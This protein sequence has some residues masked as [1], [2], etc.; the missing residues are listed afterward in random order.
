MKPESSL[1]NLEAEDDASFADPYNIPDDF[2]DNAIIEEHEPK[3]AVSIRLNRFVLDYFKRGGRGYQSRIGA[4]LRSY[5]IYQ[6][7]KE[8]DA[9]RA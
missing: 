4:V 9:K 6:M 7:T 8:L 5:V 1:T 3:E 2:W